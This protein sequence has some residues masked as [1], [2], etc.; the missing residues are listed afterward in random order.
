MDQALFNGSRVDGSAEI[1]PENRRLLTI[2]RMTDRE[3]VE[4]IRWYNLIYKPNI[5][6]KVR[7][8]GTIN[9]VQG[10]LKAYYGE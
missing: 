2:R 6:E 5:S 8:G 10:K 3:A 4:L 7:C 9:L 1:S